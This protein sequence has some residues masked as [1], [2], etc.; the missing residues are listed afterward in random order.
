MHL[1]PGGGGIPPHPPSPPRLHDVV[2][3]HRRMRNIVH[4]C[5]TGSST[6]S[7]VCS[8]DCDAL[9]LW[10]WCWLDLGHRDCEHPLVQAGADALLPDVVG[11]G[12]GAAELTEVTLTTNNLA[13]AAA[14]AAAGNLASSYM[15]VSRQARRAPFR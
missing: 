5:W 7:L 8:L 14:A 2:K 15:A 4:A 9:G 6:P 11:E 3:S 1:T 13:A 10:L 12:E